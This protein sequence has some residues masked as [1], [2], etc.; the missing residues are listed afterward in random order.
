M[1]KRALLAGINNYKSISGLRGCVNDVINVRNL[2]VECFGFN[3]SD[4]RVLLDERA[5][6]D[7]ILKRL[8]WLAD[9]SK[10]GDTVVFHFSGHGSQ[11]PDLN[12]DEQEDKL[13]ELICPWDMDW[14]GV[15]ITDDDLALYLNRISPG[16]RVEVILDCCHSGTGIR[17][18]GCRTS[19]PDIYP[20]SYR[21]VDAPPGLQLIQ[22]D[23]ESL[24]I[25]KR[26]YSPGENQV[27]WAGSQSSQTS[28]DAY[29]RGSY[30]GAFTYFLCN[31]VKRVSGN[32]TRKEV[33]SRV[34]ESI[35]KVGFEQVPQ[36]DCTDDKTMS[37]LI[38][39]NM[40]VEE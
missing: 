35:A 26:M 27:L 28:A 32:I 16:V 4:I 9:I 37:G 30:N 3:N 36:L 2:L 5:T 13:D 33:M 24:P 15:Y 22:K 40:F 8:A 12:R 19:E 10:D 7:G 23:V 29:I 21:F 38:F 17:D 18:I 25:I 14:A 31:H 6:K 11:I 39:S 1:A 20:H 34:R